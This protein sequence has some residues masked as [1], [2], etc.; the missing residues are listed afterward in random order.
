MTR[1]WGIRHLRYAYYVWRLERW[2]QDWEALGVGYG[3]P[4]DADLHHLED[5]WHGRA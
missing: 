2:A 1:W 5:I 3:V 4:A